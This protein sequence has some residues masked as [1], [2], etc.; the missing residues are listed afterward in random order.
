MNTRVLALVA[1]I[2]A[3]LTLAA[4][5][6]GG[7]T[8]VKQSQF[9]ISA[10]VTGLTGTGL[11]LQD[12]GAD[13]LTVSADGTFHF[14]TQIAANGGYNVTILTQ[15]S[16]ETC[17]LGSNAHSTATADVT[18]AVTCSANP[19]FTVSVT[20]TGLVGTLV[21][22]DD[23]SQQLTFTSNSTQTFSNSYLANATYAVTVN[24]Q[25]S[26]QTCTLS[27]NSS[28]TIT[29]A[30]ITVT[31]TCSA[32][33]TY[34]VSAAVSGLSGTLIL[35]DGFNQQLTFTADGT[36]TFT[37]TYVSNATYAVTL[38][39][40]P[41][42]ETCSL[43]ANAS[44][45]INA[46]NVTVNVTCVALPTFTLSAAVTGQT[47]GSLVLVD[48]QAQQLI[49][50]TNNT[51]TF[52]NVYFSGA[53]YSVTVLTQPAGQT[54]TVGGNGTG[55]I[56]ANTTVTVTCIPGLYFVNVN[57]TGLTGTG[58]VFQDNGGDNLP[59]SGN[60]TFTFATQVANGSPYSVTIL[61]QP[62]GQS[63]SL[64]VP[65]SGTISGAD[66]TVNVTCG[67]TTT[68]QITV[69]VTGLTG[70]L[71][72]QDDQSENLTFSSDSSQTF[73]HLYPGGS[74]YTVTVTSQPSG[75][76]CQLSGNATG[77]INANTTVTATCTTSVNS[78]EWTWIAGQKVVAVQGTYPPSTPAFPG[79]RYAAATW[80]D[81]SGNFW[82]WG[83]WGYDIN[84]PTVSCTNCG[85]N[86]SA[87]SD[88]W[89]YK[90]GAWTFKGGQA[91]TGQCFDF[92]TG[93]I[94]TTGSPSARSDAVSWTDASGNMFMFG[95]YE[96]YNTPG[97][98]N[99]ADAFN[100]MWEYSVSANTWTW[101]NGSSTQRQKGTYNGIGS[102]GTPGARYWST[103][104]RDSNGNF[105]MFGGY[106]YDSTGTGQFYINDMWEW[107][108]TTWTWVSGSSSN[109]KK[110]VYTGSSA[111]PGARAG[112]NSWFD[113]SGNFWV[114]GGLG[115][116]SA[117]A[118]G[119]LNDLWSF[120]TSTSK[121]TFVGGST[122]ANPVGSYGTQGV[123]DPSNVPGGRAW[124]VSWLTPSG[125][126]YIL[127]G[128]QLGGGLL[129]DLWKYSGGQWTWIAPDMPSDG[130]QF[131]NEL[132]IYG[133][134]GV[135]N[136][137][138]APGSREQGMSWTDASGNLW[139]LGGFGWG[140]IPNGAGTNVHAGTDSLNDIWEFQP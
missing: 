5:G 127:G 43:G 126:V 80:Q 78:G 70:T 64:G 138:N 37:A 63:C 83:G 109:G 132:G 10:A 8:V 123:A 105:W 24:T 68:Y 53:T 135:A 58:L 6:G 7:M 34:T 76:N 25:P 100:D 122:T 14:A 16:G 52:S 66:V 95:G 112:A 55:T 23:A 113:S 92:P 29:T 98:C 50:T 131:V 139:L 42:G 125:D 3:L 75:Q 82:M 72:V 101:V 120:N 93:G 46:A 62:T 133:T 27:A 107:N 12:N 84:G 41:A 48:D 116:D 136:S 111:V 85:S 88:L 21:V 59:V 22:Q 104:Q 32:I 115:I 67:A 20:T 4:C 61:T 106:A 81:A 130:S 124:A 45:T 49:F 65:S 97:S 119:E 35:Q 96:V 77:S 89:E 114:F 128:Q 74:S 54:C 140:T 2:G 51:Q 17:T 57:V 30:N 33:P 19:T 129:N 137:A 36:Q 40:Q 13:N 9:T 117:G 56:A 94:G 1:S 134:L 18:V 31:A 71:I 103:G 69:T 118:V 15:P 44:G 121:W 102:T 99:L 90:G 26:G 86:E 91:Q 73:P 38:I 11:V 39:S 110:G 28:G 60:G 108:G 87:L 47:G 79:T